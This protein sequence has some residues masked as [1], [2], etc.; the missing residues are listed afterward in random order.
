[1]NPSLELI[2]RKAHKTLEVLDLH[3]DAF[4]NGDFSALKTLA[5]LGAPNLHTLTF[6]AYQNGSIGYQTLSTL[7]AKCPSLLTVELSEI[8]FS[9][10][11]AFEALLGSK[12]LQQLT[13]TYSL[14]KND[15]WSTNIGRVPEANYFDGMKQFFE[16]AHSLNHFSLV[17]FDPL[18]TLR[19]GFLNH[20]T[21]AI[22]LSTVRTVDLLP[23]GLDE[24]DVLL[25]LLVNLRRSQIRTLKIRVGSAVGDAEIDALAEIQHLTH[26]IVHDDGGNF[27]QSKL[28]QLLDKW[29][30]PQM[31]V[32]HVHAEDNHCI[33]GHKAS[34]G[35]MRQTKDLEQSK[36]IR[37]SISTKFDT[38]KENMILSRVQSDTDDEFNEYVDDYYQWNWSENELF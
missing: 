20:L 18:T 19:A 32:V 28:F 36:E 29:E 37:Y 5:E 30:K 24:S 6:H 2:L 13:M 27:G 31:L 3:L 17:S 21:Q 22:G 12:R 11:R 35:R 14:E 7:L 4:Q 16:S 10:D 23:N 8:S 26:L 1:M 15:T 33:I 25:D 9:F 38:C 34:V